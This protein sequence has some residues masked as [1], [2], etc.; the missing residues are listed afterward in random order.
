MKACEYVVFTPAAAS[1]LLYSLSPKRISAI[2]RAHFQPFSLSAAPNHIAFPAP[3]KFLLTKT[4]K[5][6]SQGNSRKAET[7]GEQRY[8]GARKR[9]NGNVARESK[10][11]AVQGKDRMATERKRNEDVRNKQKGGVTRKRQ[12]YGG[13]RKRRQ[14][15][16]RG[17]E[18][19]ETA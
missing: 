18:S 19:G 15:R 1:F 6:V 10:K 12:K 9:Q 2:H 14:H 8:G 3:K 13:A 5:A 16:G 4:S 11:A 17:A 7:Q